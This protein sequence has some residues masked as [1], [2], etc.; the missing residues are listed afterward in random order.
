MDYYIYMHEYISW[1]FVYLTSISTHFTI[2]VLV[3]LDESGP[4]AEREWIDV[5]MALFI[6]PTPSIHLFNLI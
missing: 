6:N 3:Q 2:L 5:F 1:L 4:A